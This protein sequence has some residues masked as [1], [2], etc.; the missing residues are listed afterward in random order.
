M[1][2]EQAAVKLLFETSDS[3]HAKNEA[4]SLLNKF[5]DVRNTIA[6]PSGNITWPGGSRRLK[7]TSFFFEV[8]ADTLSQIAQVYTV[9]LVTKT[10]AAPVAIAPRPRSRRLLP[11]ALLEA[12]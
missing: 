1:V 7:A 6:H 12:Q 11:E 2:G 4:Q 9:S 3:S 5:M 8:L 10:P